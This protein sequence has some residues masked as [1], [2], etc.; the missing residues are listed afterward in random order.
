MPGVGADLEG[1]GLPSGLSTFSVQIVTEERR[2]DEF[3]KFAR[4]LMSAKTN[5]SNAIALRA[6]PLIVVPR[7]C[8][9]EICV[10]RIAFLRVAVNGFR[11]EV[12]ESLLYILADEHQDAN[13]AQNALLELLVEYSERPNIFI[14]GDEKQAIYRFQGADL[15]NV[16]YFRERFE[17]TR[18]FFR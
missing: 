5:R 1:T 14:V 9:N 12:Q 6:Q 4:G 10:F 18:S 2:F 3:A 8:D 7:S 11:R 17:G 16:Q 15:D 13:R